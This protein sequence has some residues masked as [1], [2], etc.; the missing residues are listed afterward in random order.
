MPFASEKQR[1]FLWLNYPKIARKW[2]EKYTSPLTQSRSTHRKRSPEKRKKRSTRRKR[3]PE[4]R[5]KR[6]TRRNRSPEKRKKRSTRRKKIKGGMDTS[7]ITANDKKNWF[8]PRP[9]ARTK[10]TVSIS[11]HAK[12]WTKCKQGPGPYCWLAASLLALELNDLKYFDKVVSPMQTLTTG[13]GRQFDGYFVR[14]MTPPTSIQNWAQRYKIKDL[15]PRPQICFIFDD[16]LMQKETSMS[17]KCQ[18]LSRNNEA[19]NIE[20]CSR[21]SLQP[22]AI[23]NAV[24]ILLARGTQKR[25]FEALAGRNVRDSKEAFLTV[26]PTLEKD[27]IKRKLLTV[28]NEWKDANRIINDEDKIVVLTLTG[29]NFKK[30]RIWKHVVVPIKSQLVE[31]KKTKKI[32]ITVRDPHSPLVD[33]TFSLELRPSNPLTMVYSKKTGNVRFSP[34]EAE[35]AAINYFAKSKLEEVPKT[36]WD[37]VKDSWPK[38]KGSPYY[39]LVE[40]EPDG[41]SKINETKNNVKISEGERFRE[42]LKSAREEA[43][44]KILDG[45]VETDR[46]AVERGT[47]RLRSN[48]ISPEKHAR[49]VEGGTSRKKI[50]CGMRSPS[51][52]RKRLYGRGNILRLMS[53][54]LAAIE[55][56]FINSVGAGNITRVTQL[57]R[58]YPDIVNAKGSDGNTALIEAAKGDDLRSLV[59]LLLAAGADVNAKNDYGW[60]ALMMAVFH[61]HVENAKLLLEAG[62]DVNA[63]NNRGLT[64]LMMAAQYFHD[65]VENAELLLEAG[66][67]VNVKNNRGQTALMIANNNDNERMTD[68]F[69]RYEKYMTHLYYKPGGDGYL[70]ALARYSAEAK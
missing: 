40:N 20:K 9:R 3:S 11:D 5:K 31:T 46:V 22:Q 4:K 61:D 50:K 42:T 60:T 48:E 57:L 23:Q 39:C 67:D 44:L 7:P 32:T 47:R 24:A 2:A 12:S 14:L 66:A 8:W 17:F 56:E 1:R 30:H 16:K 53:P 27:D 58:D 54:P 34:H 64:A 45:A 18:V 10:G 25:P 19:K 59:V 51:A 33:S 63:K 28:P 29:F 55:L 52:K 15:K 26:V 36:N 68:L 62:A 37:I 41:R 13:G 43:R 6:S 38:T 35:A 70:A 49:T 69:D 21:Y 65:H